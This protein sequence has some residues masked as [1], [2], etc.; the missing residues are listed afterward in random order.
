MLLS[1]LPLQVA[2]L[3]IAPEFTGKDYLAKGVF[4]FL[5][6]LQRD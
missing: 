5:E 3:G 1:P 2:V 4:F 6:Q